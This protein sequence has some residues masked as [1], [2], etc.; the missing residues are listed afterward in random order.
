MRRRSA[1]RIDARRRE[2]DVRVSHWRRT[3]EERSPV[4]RYAMATLSR[5]RERGFHAPYLITPLTLV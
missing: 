2:D 4:H 3:R 1:I 5:K